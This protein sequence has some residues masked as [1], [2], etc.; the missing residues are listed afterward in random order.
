MP[1]SYLNGRLRSMG[2]AF[3]GLV[4]LLRTQHNARIHLVATV[5]VCV[6]G[7]WLR[8]SLTDWCLIV[9]AV[10]CVWVAEALNTSLEFLVDLASPGMHPLAEKAKDVAAGGVLVAALGAA[11]I[12]ALVFGPPLW[13]VL[14][15]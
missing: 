11:L 9:F 12:G 10:L 6:L 5:L 7:A 1:D 2:H 8:I 15:R 14:Q 4:T 3:R 13:E